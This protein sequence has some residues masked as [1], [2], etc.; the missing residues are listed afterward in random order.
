[1]PVLAFPTSSVLMVMEKTG[2]SRRNNT[3]QAADRPE[4]DMKEGFGAVKIITKTYSDKDPNLKVTKSVSGRA[5]LSTCHRGTHRFALNEKPEIKR[6][7]NIHYMFLQ[8][9][10]TQDLQKLR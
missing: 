8:R 4:K 5:S 2:Q 6:C 10:K 9:V 1:M 3:L 7:I